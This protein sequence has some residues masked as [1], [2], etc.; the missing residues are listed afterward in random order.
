MLVVVEDV[1]WILSV[2]MRVIF[3]FERVFIVYMC[4]YL[5]LLFRSLGGLICW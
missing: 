5:F 3:K 4:A 1:G 2:L